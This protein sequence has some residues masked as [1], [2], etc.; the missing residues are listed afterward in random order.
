MAYLEG[1]PIKEARARQVSMTYGPARKPTAGPPIQ[2]SLNSSQYLEMKAVK[3]QQKALQEEIKILRETTIHRINDKINVL[4]GDLAATNEKITNFDAR[5]DNVEKQQLEMTN[6]QT[7]GFDKLEGILTSLITSS[8]QHINTQYRLPH[9]SQQLRTANALGIGGSPWLP[10][11]P[12]S[13]I[14]NFN[15]ENMELEEFRD[16]LSSTNLEIVFLGE[17]HWANT[18]NFKFKSY[19]ILKKIRPNRMGG[20]VAILVHRALQFAPLEVKTS[21]TV[22]AIGVKIMFTNSVQFNFISVSVLKGDFDTKEVVHLINHN[23]DFITT[24]DFNGH[25]VKWESDVRPNKAR[26]SI[27]EAL[28]QNKMHA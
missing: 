7:V 4:V 21:T 11:R 24:G 18:H 15:E 22:E 8:G 17:T 12:T 10:Q 14:F 1:I 2:D 20:E 6:K 27:Y 3:E 25:H 23:N 9:P 26:Q 13:S 5:F 28:I 16:L 19:Y